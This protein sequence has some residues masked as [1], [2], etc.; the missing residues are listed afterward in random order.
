MKVVIPFAYMAQVILPRSDAPKDEV[1]VETLEV[2]VP[3]YHSGEIP[4]ALSFR[5][6]DGSPGNPVYLRNDQFLSGGRDHAKIILDLIPRK[7]GLVYFHPMQRHLYEYGSKRL[8]AVNAWYE[9]GKAGRDPAKVIDWIRTDRDEAFVEAKSF[10]EGMVAL[11]GNL[12][13]PAREPTISLSAYHDTHGSTAQVSVASYDIGNSTQRGHPLFF[14]PFH[15]TQTAEAV[16]FARQRYGNWELEV[17]F[18]QDLN[19]A[20]P[21]AFTF[22]IGRHSLEWA[23][24]DIFEALCANIRHVPDNLI[25]DWQS[26]RRLVMDKAIPG[27]EEK[28]A[29]IVDALIPAVRNGPQRKDLLSMLQLWA[30][31]E[32]VNISLNHRQTA[33]RA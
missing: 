1:F 25:G 30:E 16:E 21:E 32:T 22:E 28:V 2:D 4:L 19:I 27:W 18:N 20:I 17:Q 6:R 7:P 11:D 9:E 13:F 5:L 12:L 31:S 24:A 14:P 23:V 29:P 3:E 15:I 26:L 10:F 8:N 33:P